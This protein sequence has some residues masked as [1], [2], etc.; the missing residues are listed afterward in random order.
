AQ[1][2]GLKQGPLNS[3]S[4]P[5][6]SQPA[7]VGSTVHML[8]GRATRLADLQVKVRENHFIFFTVRCR[9]LGLLEKLRSD[10]RINV[11]D[12]FA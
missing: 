11:D 10:E 2:A 9:L 5:P 8:I 4:V 3:K 12:L 6:G 1:L 7:G